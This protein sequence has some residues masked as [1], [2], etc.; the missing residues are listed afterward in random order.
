M[1]LVKSITLDFFPI[2]YFKTYLPVNSY[3]II[4]ILVYLNI[5]Q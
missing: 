1:E 3:K 5:P 4:I 2:S